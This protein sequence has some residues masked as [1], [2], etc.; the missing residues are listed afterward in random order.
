MQI[1]VLGLGEAG[2]LYAAGLVA[3]G[4]TV[5]GFDPGDVATP[6][7]V[8]RVASAEDAA[9]DADIVLSLVGARFAATA[10]AGA[11]PA[12]ADGDAIYADLNTGSPAQKAELAAQAAASGIAFV[13]VAVMAPV[14]RA[15]ASTPLL[16]SGAGAEAFR[17]R[18]AGFDVPIDSAGPEAGAAAGLKLVRSILM[19]G[20]AGLLLESLSAAGK[21]DAE[22]W[23]RAQIVGELGPGSEELID[24]LIEG[25]RQHAARRVHEMTDVREFLD[26]LG[27]PSWMTE[28]ALRWLRSLSDDAEVAVR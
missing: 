13:D 16:V 6:D 15:G 8:E 14:P 10:L 3:R 7:G 26:R 19:K 1:A 18:L 24:R 21:L 27:S 20:L 22:D 9:R 23:M 25:S 12:M 2:S 28:G 17:D 11:L 5:R 4:A